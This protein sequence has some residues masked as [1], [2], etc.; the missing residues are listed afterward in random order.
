VQ[1]RP[2]R[3]TRLAG[4]LAIGV[5]APV[6]AEYLVAY[7]EITGDLVESVAALVFFVPLY[8]GA[9]LL[10]RELAERAGMG[11]SGRLLLAAAFGVSMTSVIDVSLWTAH[12]P[13]ID[14]WDDIQSAARLDAFGFSA[15]AA[16]IWVLGH[17]MM[18][19]GAPLAL[20]EALLPRIRGARLL[21]RA[22][23]VCWSAAFLAVAAMIHFSEAG[24]YDVHP[25]AAQYAGAAAVVVVLVA[26]AFG[27]AGRP[28]RSRPGRTTPRPW[29]LG[30]LGALGMA[31]VDLEPAGWPGV[32]IMVVVETVGCVL[33]LHWS[34]STGWTWR[35]VAALAWGAL[36]VRTL[37][38]FLSPIPDGVSVA[39]KVAHSVVL[40]VLVLGLGGLLVRRLTREAGSPGG[41]PAQ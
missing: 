15:Y 24:E 10:I 25:S 38:G 16:L 8:G 18:S 1:A 29:V 37:E 30:L 34:G 7:L 23:L 9:A 27:R 14:Y 6:C 26:L 21:G 22:G 36:V 19:V 31:G 41:V 40:L 13:D 17:V 5:V 32:G 12:R 3:R 11:W 20:A 28:S 2:D 4:V 39:A 33:L 35:H